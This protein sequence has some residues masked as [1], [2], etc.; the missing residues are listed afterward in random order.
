[1]AGQDALYPVYHFQHARAKIPCAQPKRKG[2][3]HHHT[4]YQSQYAR[5]S[6]TECVQPTLNEMCD[7][8]KLNKTDAPATV[9]G[10]PFARHPA[11]SPSSSSS[12]LHIS[13]P[14]PRDEAN[15]PMYH[16]RL[17]VVANSRIHKMKISSPSHLPSVKPVLA[18][19]EVLGE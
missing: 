10:S 16:P 11:A 19:L 4:L 9:P 7:H 8:S 18:A 15:V 14:V 17:S 3:R 6:L 1:M 2:T 13:D 12:L 5:F